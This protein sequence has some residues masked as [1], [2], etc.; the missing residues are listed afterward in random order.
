MKTI[1]TWPEVSETDISGLTE[2]RQEEH[3]PG[4]QCM[5]AASGL[6]R[7]R[8]RPGR[9]SPLRDGD[10]IS[11][12]VSRRALCRC[13]SLAWRA[14]IRRD[15][16]TMDAVRASRANGR[17]VFARLEGVN[18]AVEQFPS[19]VF[20]RRRRRHPSIGGWD[21]GAGVRIG[22]GVRRECGDD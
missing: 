10:L 19:D 9:G 16:T 13:K 7:L 21:G 12:E 20:A 11:A 14:S 8:R 2:G 17:L 22:D 4:S 3:A 5:A 6:A 1:A 18:L 15:G